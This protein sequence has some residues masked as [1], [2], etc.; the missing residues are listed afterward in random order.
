MYKSQYAIVRITFRLFTFLLFL[1]GIIWAYSN[2]QFLGN[3]VFDNFTGSAISI[4]NAQA[5]LAEDGASGYSIPSVTDF[6]PWGIVRTYLLSLNVALFR[7]YIWEVRNPLMLLNALE[8]LSVLL[9]TIYLLV[10]TKVTGFFKFSLKNSLLFFALVFSLLMAPLAGFVSFNFG[11]LVRYKF[12]AVPL[13]YT[14][15]LLLYSVLNKKKS[16]AN[17]NK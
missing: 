8:S 6:S 14:Y 2:I 13:F 15:L 17:F 7:P 3:L 5:A 16:V 1:G 10:K 9:L 4:Q 11:T 12:P